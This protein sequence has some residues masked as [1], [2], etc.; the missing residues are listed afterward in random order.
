[1][2][3]PPVRLLVLAIVFGGVVAPYPGQAQSTGFADRSVSNAGPASS[4]PRVVERAN[5]F[6]FD[7]LRTTGATTDDSGNVF[8]SPTSVHMALSMALGGAREV[9]RQEMA[10]TLHVGDISYG[11]LGDGYRSFVGRLDSLDSTVDLVLANSLWYRKDNDLD[12]RLGFLDSTRRYFQANV[13]ELDF[14]APGASRRINGWVDQTTRGNISE[15]VPSRIPRETVMYLINATYFK[16]EWQTPFDTA[17]TAPEPFH[18]ADGTTDEVP[19]MK[20]TRASHRY[21]R[22]ESMTAVDLPYGD[23]TYSMRILLPKEG[24]SPWSLVDTLD[25]DDWARLTEQMHSQ[26][27]VRLWLPA[28]TLRYETGLEDVLKGLGMERAFSHKGKNRANFRSIADTS[29][30]IS[31]V[32]HKTFLQVDE[33]GTEASAAT[34]VNI[35]LDNESVDEPTLPSVIVDRPFVVAIRERQSGAIL[36]LGVVTNPVA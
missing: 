2:S 35:S 27:L 4:G 30:H 8:L 12:V 28:F 34:S 15:I 11:D 32:R 3:A 22:T 5:A 29:L 9:T 18:L 21:V 10:T 13:S 1:M 25:T 33:S 17:R 14:T 26:E 23:G 24:I 19:M 20:Q 7:L 31:G 16:G 36:F 6:G